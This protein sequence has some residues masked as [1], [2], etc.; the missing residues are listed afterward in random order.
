MAVKLT[1]SI[2]KSLGDEATND[3][4]NL[5]EGTLVTKT[6][7]QQGISSLQEN[8]SKTRED[9]IRELS[10]TREQFLEKLASSQKEISNQNQKYW[11]GTIGVNIA[12]I[13]ALV[14]I[15]LSR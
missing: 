13:T 15:F 1:E 9:F 3:F 6:E 12:L 11:L 10:F 8:I 14:A 2:R 5:L 4:E 7:F